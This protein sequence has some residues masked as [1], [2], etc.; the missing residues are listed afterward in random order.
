MPDSEGDKIRKLMF[1]PAPAWGDRG[2]RTRT[3]R[4]DIS[5][6]YEKVPGGLDA[7]VEQ[8]Q[9]A[10]RDNGGRP[11]N[12]AGID[13]L[14]PVIVKAVD[15]GLGY[16]NPRTG[17]VAISDSLLADHRLRQ[18]VLEHERSHR[19]FGTPAE[20]GP[21]LP[22][23]ARWL[24]QG[25]A[26]YV[27]KP[28]EIDVRIADIKR[29]YAHAT[30]RLVNSPEEAEKA[31]MWFG[32]NFE[33]LPQE[34]PDASGKADKEVAAEYITLPPPERERLLRRMM[35]VVSNDRPPSVG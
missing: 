12:P 23:R 3:L 22:G 31:I 14:S 34:G 32:R 11:W 33:S 8:A 29:K 6:W 15:K 21:I 28:T 24:T 13:A 27:T 20:N 25:S 1:P 17:E 5:R 19:L 35:E 4:D 9:E 2:P 7:A 26:E 30:G 10:I 18:S 16:H